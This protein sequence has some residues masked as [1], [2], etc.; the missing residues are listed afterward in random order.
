[1]VMAIAQFDEN[2]LEDIYNELLALYRPTW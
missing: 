1:M 2:R